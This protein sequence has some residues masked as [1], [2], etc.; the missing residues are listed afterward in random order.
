MKVIFLDIDGV[1]N[2]FNSLAKYG[3]DY[4]DQNAVELVAQIVKETKAKIVLTSTWRLN[5][6]DLE[7]VKKSLMVSGIGL[8]D[9]TKKLENKARLEEIKEWLERHPEVKRFVILDDDEDAG[10]G[11]DGFFITDPEI[12]I[13]GDIAGKASDHLGAQ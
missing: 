10:F 1:L 11:M 7:L 13:T 5:E 8:E 2:N 9:C 6:R 4:I 3:L 12:G